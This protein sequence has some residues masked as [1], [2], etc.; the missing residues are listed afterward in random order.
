MEEVNILYI[1]IV[2][3]LI[4]SCHMYTEGMMTDVT[5]VRASFDKKKYM[6]RNKPGK[7]KAANI[8]AKICD[9]LKEFIENLNI[10]HPNNESCKRLKDR[11]SVDNV[12]ESSSTD[13]YTSYSVNKGEQIVFCLRS[14]D[15]KEAIHD[16]NTIMF[17]ALHEM[18]H[19]MSKSIGHNK[20]FWDNFAF[21]LKNAI[22]DGKYT[23]QNFKEKPV[24]Y[25]GTKITDSPIDR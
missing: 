2:I 8:L 15:G 22:E 9:S 10:K 21:L 12:S 18:G 23:Y 17:V 25:C 7:R 3:V 14:K 11:F 16:E 24:E 1:I 19:L 4:L 6:V 5:L 20:E 13:K